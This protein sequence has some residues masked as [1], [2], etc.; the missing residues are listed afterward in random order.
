[1]GATLRP[2]A[3]A[4]LVQKISM[5]ANK[6]GL[7]KDITPKAMK[8]IERMEGGIGNPV[9]LT[10]LDTLRKV[11]GN[12]AGSLEKPDAAIGMQIVD[13]IDDYLENIPGSAFETGNVNPAEVSK[14]YESARD[15]WGR[16]RR[17]EVIQEA[18]DKARL[19]A[20][21]FENGIRT[22][23]RQILNNKKL[24][25][26]FKPAEREAM[27]KVVK[28]GRAENLARLI[29]R[30]APSEGSAH[31]VL[32]GMAGVAGGA[33]VGGPVGA[34]L[35]PG[36]GYVSRNMAQKM[37]AKNA[38]F[39]DQLIR[40]GVDSRRITQAYF[41][42]T[43]PKERSA[44]E[45]SELLMSKDINFDTLPKNEIAQTA[46][47]LAFKRRNELEKLIGAAGSTGAV[48]AYANEDK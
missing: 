10:E 11:A 15:L 40:S 32:T 36:I 6:S 22:Q 47:I 20:S 23:F 25:K 2:D 9:T 1:M 17:S 8:V 39:A 19:Q 5:N 18:F 16:A 43:P 28:G 31:N 38:E 3:Y 44:E 35:V 45:L 30:F 7:D 37:T 33:A 46:K 26:R 41:K 4:S 24:S 34:V 48:S 42:N 13:S 27:K 12:A 29:G 21:G 14:K